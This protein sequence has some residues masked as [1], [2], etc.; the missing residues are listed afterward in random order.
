MASK[1]SDQVVAAVPP[2]SEVITPFAYNI[3]QAAIYTGCAVWNLRV[4]VWGGTLRARLA[5]K[6]FI[7]TKADLDDFVLSLPEVRSGKCVNT[8]ARKRRAA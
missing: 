3:Q 8:S 5:G 1:K 2:A 4:A 6:K 7:F